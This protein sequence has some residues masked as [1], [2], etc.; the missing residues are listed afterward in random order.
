MF[1]R[2]QSSL[3]L[4]EAAIVVSPLTKKFVLV[5]LW[6]IAPVLGNPRPILINRVH[7]LSSCR[8]TPMQA[9][10]STQ[11]RNFIAQKIL[12]CMITFTLML[13]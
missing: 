11:L 13:I 9:L 12:M 8:L 7:Y 1:C 3:P 10:S 2:I 6:F 4:T 5:I